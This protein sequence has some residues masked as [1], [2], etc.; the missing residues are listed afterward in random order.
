MQSDSYQ[1]DTKEAQEAEVKDQHQGMSYE[2]VVDEMRRN[3]EY[4]IELDNLKPQ[5]H[6]WVDRG[7]K[8]TCEG[9]NHAYHEAWKRQPRYS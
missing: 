2:Q 7:L 6:N 5:S 8:M 3:S 9:S 1:P 4:S